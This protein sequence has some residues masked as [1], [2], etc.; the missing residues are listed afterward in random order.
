YHHVAILDIDVGEKDL[1]QCADAWIR[2]YAEFLWLQKRYEEIE[3]QF[4]SGQK[5]SWIDYQ[6]G[7]RTTEVGN[8]VRFHRTAKPDNSYSN[9]RNYLDLI[10]RYAGTISL[11]RESLPIKKNADI[12]VGDIIIKPGSP[13]HSVIIVGSAKNSAGKRLFLLAESFMPAQDIHII[14]NPQ[15][16]KLS[17]W[18]ELDVDARQLITPKYLFAPLVI[19][20]FY[21]I[22]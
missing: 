17:P 16:P 13:G 5:M 20:R 15:N 21:G 9:F 14:K 12:K 8:K 1:Q 10:F 22:K 6:K 19:K 4:T 18:Y 7:I 11:D 2:L 3:F